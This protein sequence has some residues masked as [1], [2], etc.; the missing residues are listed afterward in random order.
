M[1]IVTM[2]VSASLVLSAL[3]GN[4]EYQGSLR[5]TTSCDSVCQMRAQ[6]MA[7]SLLVET[8]RQFK[9]CQIEQQFQRRMTGAENLTSRDSKGSMVLKD[10]TETMRKLQEFVRGL[11]HTERTLELEH[12]QTEVVNFENAYNCIRREDE[13]QLGIKVANVVN[14]REAAKQLKDYSIVSQGAPATTDF[15]PGDP[16]PA[17]MVL[18]DIEPA[19]P[20]PSQVIEGC[21]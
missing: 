3:A 2:I 13:K 6:D 7:F 5:A 1:S 21:D 8:Y 4:E 14:L 9:S 16:L 20:A 17:D 19:S 11:A 18:F 12:L 10:D 15:Q